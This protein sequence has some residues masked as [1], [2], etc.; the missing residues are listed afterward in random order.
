MNYSLFSWLLLAPYAVCAQQAKPTIAP[1][2]DNQKLL[3]SPSTQDTPI[4]SLWPSQRPAALAIGLKVGGALTAKAGENVHS[5]PPTTFLPGGVVG[6]YGV[7]PLQWTGARSPIA[8]NLQA[9]LLASMQGSRYN[10]PRDTYNVTFRH[11]YLCL[12]VLVT[13]HYHRVFLAGGLQASYLMAVRERYESEW[14]NA[15]MVNTSKRTN[16]YQR[17]ELAFVGGIGYRSKAGLSIEARYVQGIT[18]L[19]RNNDGRVPYYNYWATPTGQHNVGYQV[20]V[21]YPL[22]NKLVSH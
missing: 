19:Y 1:D 5:I 2:S 14:N 8:F 20:Q 17:P 16:D 18:N 9:E 3:A 13:A 22:F 11:Y 4:P 7:M 21:S 12:P 6:V 15:P 10:K